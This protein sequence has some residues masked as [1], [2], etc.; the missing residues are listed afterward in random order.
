[1][2]ER[3]VLIYHVLQAVEDD[4]EH[5]V[6]MT[7]LESKADLALQAGSNEGGAKPSWMGIIAA[8][9]QEDYTRSCT[10]ASSWCP[11]SMKGTS[12]NPTS[13]GS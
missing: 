2:T 4:K 10:R 5:E 11:A 9:T 8:M 6:Y 13:G 3:K 12:W 1:M 7:E